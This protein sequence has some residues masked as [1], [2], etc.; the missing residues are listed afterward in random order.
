MF[1]NVFKMSNKL[2]FS[3][4]S[5]R[6]L[7]LLPFEPGLDADRSKCV[8]VS[9]KAHCWFWCSSIYQWAPVAGKSKGLPSRHALLPSQRQCPGGGRGA[10]EWQLHCRTGGHIPPWSHGQLMTKPDG[11]IHFWTRSE[12]HQRGP[13]SRSTRDINVCA[14]LLTPGNVVLWDVGKQT[15]FFSILTWIIVVVI[16]D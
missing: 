4:D 11:W 5:K 6:S 8:V 2:S 12:M 10:P 16:W 15:L 7:T 1:K 9:S 13:V 14:F 3:W